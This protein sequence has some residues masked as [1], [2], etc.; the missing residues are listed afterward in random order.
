MEVK[1]GGM[2]GKKDKSIYEALGLTRDEAKKLEND[3]EFQCI[4]RPQ[5]VSTSL[6]W[7]VWM[8]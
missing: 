7:L 4:Q 6:P 5:P 3:A 2:K 8:N 1:K